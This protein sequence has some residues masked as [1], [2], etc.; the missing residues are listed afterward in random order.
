[1]NG[2]FRT[3]LAILQDN[4][5]EK[6][7]LPCSWKELL[8]TATREDVF[9]PFYQKLKQTDR[10]QTIPKEVLTQMEQTWYTTLTHQT[11]ALENL[12]AIAGAFA[13][14]SIR[15]ILFKGF[16][17]ALRGY[18]NLWLR[19][20]T[21]LD[22]MI[23]PEDLDRAKAILV[24]LKFKPHTHSPLDFSRSSFVVELH[25]GINHLKRFQHWEQGPFCLEGFW[26]RQTTL[27]LEG[28]PLPVLELHDLLLALS[29]HLTFH[30]HLRGL[31]WLLD[32]AC[33]I[34]GHE[35][36]WNLLVKRAIEN[37][38]TPLLLISLKRVQDIF[39]IPLPP[40]LL[41]TLQANK[42]PFLFF[43][44][45][46]TPWSRYLF[47]LGTLPTFKQ[48]WRMLQETISPWR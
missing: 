1:M 24:G 34:Q 12:R 20:Q 25:K 9:L 19:N 14:E 22:F 5:G 2:A 38:F 11:L 4:F 17:L 15:F 21:D 16:D 27:L 23:Y 40:G 13:K 36:D 3:L 41:D 43:R 46:N 7:P 42:N 33:L 45:W 47:R 10:I 29:F 18:G 28:L 32:I 44:H 31:K 30:H 35:I 37:R 39:S 6:N 8:Q 26:G 48:R